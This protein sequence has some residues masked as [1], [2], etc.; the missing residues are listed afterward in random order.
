MGDTHVIQVMLGA[1]AASLTLAAAAFAADSSA[2]AVPPLAFMGGGWRTTPTFQAPPSGP[3]PV[4]DMPGRPRVANNLSLGQ[5]VFPMADLSNPILQPWAREALK[6]VNDHIAAGGGGFSPQVSCKLLG[7]PAFL[8]HT[9]RAIYFIQTAKEVVM[10]API[11]A[12]YRHIYLTDRHSPNPKPS[13]YGESIGHYENGDTLVVDT[14]GLNDKTYVDNFRT[15]HTTQLHVVERY[16]IDPDGKGL[17][18]NVRVEDPGAFT[19]PWNAVVRAQRAEEDPLN[20]MR[21]E[22]CAENPVNH[23]HED[24]EPV[25]QAGKADF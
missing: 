24:R 12:E 10:V 8:L 4:L 22:A 14:I 3:G 13:W 18:V 23:L 17:T 20:P 6:K 7:V 19:T 2:N 25:P 9:G 16:R 15:P 1:A 11:N 5:P 21:E